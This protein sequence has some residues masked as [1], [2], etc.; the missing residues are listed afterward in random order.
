MFVTIVTTLTSS[1]Y[2]NN[3]DDLSVQYYQGRK[4]VRDIEKKELNN[5]IASVKK[6]DSQAES[7]YKLA[8]HFQKRRRHN[9]AIEEFE[10]AIHLDPSLSKAYNAIGISYDKLGFHQK[11]I[12]CYKRALELN[13]KYDRAHNNLGFSYM[14]IKKYDS[15]I[16]SFKKA[17][18]INNK[19]RRFK[20]NLVLAYIMKEDYY[21]AIKQI[22]SYEDGKNSEEIVK[23]IA[24]EIAPKYSE[25]E[26]YLAIQKVRH[27]DALVENKI[28]TLNTTIDK[29]IEKEVHIEKIK[30]NPNHKNTDNNA[31]EINLSNKRLISINEEN[32]IVTN[33]ITLATMYHNDIPK[34]QEDI[35]SLKST[36]SEGS[37]HTENK[38]STDIYTQKHNSTVNDNNLTKVESPEVLDSTHNKDYIT[39]KWEDDSDFNSAK[40]NVD[41]N[42]LENNTSNKNDHRDIKKPK[43]YSRKHKIT[44]KLESGKSNTSFQH[45]STH[46]KT[47]VSLNERTVT[48]VDTN[49]DNT[50]KK[51]TSTLEHKTENKINTI[52]TKTVSVH[53]KSITARTVNLKDYKVKVR[54]DTTIKNKKAKTTKKIYPIY[55]TKVVKTNRH[56]NRNISVI[57]LSRVEQVN[58]LK[59][60]TKSIGTQKNDTLGNEV[61]AVE[62]ANGNGV[63]GIARKYK[64]LIE[65]K[66]VKVIKISNAN[67]SEHITT[68]IFYY[69][70]QHNDVRQLIKE[71][72][73]FPDKNCLIEYRKSGRNIKIIIGKDVIKRNSAKLVEKKQTRKRI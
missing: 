4:S 43:N 56:Q 64:K 35:E 17:I 18:N 69:A 62:I 45:V 27:E 12:D 54:D 19:N 59:R 15:A 63:N 53:Q 50:N 32:E 10:N 71:I 67:Y 25:K 11:A 47:D 13:K 39:V 8:L 2:L 9:L 49:E 7:H 68:K 14:N 57:N 61:I 16:E 41:F 6:V 72:G 26:L 66:G 20:N 30:G 58:N 48:N 33:G 55:T 60:N 24:K 3:V 5:F 42:N 73:V 36:L 46:Q 37:D 52:R 28:D 21:S 31:T 34:S 51:G 29:K 40:E 22:K 65:K 1:C 44:D 38:E 23:K 70:E